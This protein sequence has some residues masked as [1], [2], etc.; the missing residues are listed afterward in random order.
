LLAANAFAS[1]ESGTMLLADGRS[2]ASF[3]LKEIRLR[4]Q[5]AEQPHVREIRCAGGWAFPSSVAFPT[6]REMDG[7]LGA[8][9]KIDVD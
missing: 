4:L 9:I 1:S 8:L 7:A 3:V 5:S 6:L 2:G